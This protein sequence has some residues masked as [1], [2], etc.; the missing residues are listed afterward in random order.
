MPIIFI[1]PATEA[2][3]AAVRGFVEAMP[4]AAAGRL[5]TFANLRE[6][7]AAVEK[8]SNIRLPNWWVA[9]RWVGT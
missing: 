3:A 4:V 6:C 9:A 5:N 7:S 2:A 1:A 8:V